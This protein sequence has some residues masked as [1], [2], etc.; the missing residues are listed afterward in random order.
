LFAVDVFLENDMG[1]L[2]K[3]PGSRR[4]PAGLEWVLLRKLPLIAVA[5]TAA[6]AVVAAAAWLL[7]A[8]DPASQK[9]ATT[10]LIA[11]ASAVVLHLT[12]VFTL[13]LACVIVLIAKGPAYVA[14]AYPLIDSDR[15]A[16]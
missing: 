8:S 2:T 16:R 1:L 11:A 13:A 4:S 6:V 5:G 9:L 3:L 7:A 14:D 10:L 12:A 15:P